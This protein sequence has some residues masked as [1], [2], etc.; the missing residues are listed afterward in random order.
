LALGLQISRFSS[1]LRFFALTEENFL[2]KLVFSTLLK[3]PAMSVN[4]A[5]GAYLAL[6]A[7]WALEDC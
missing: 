4:G 5:V 7:Y 6:G 2:P 1:F 3:K